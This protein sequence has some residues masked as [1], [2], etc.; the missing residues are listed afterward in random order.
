MEQ[1]ASLCPGL[2][3]CDRVRTGVGAQPPRGNVISSLESIMG[4]AVSFLVKAQG[5]GKNH[6][7]FGMLS[8]QH[9]IWEEQHLPQNAGRSDSLKHI[10]CSELPKEPGP[11]VGHKSSV[12][13]FEALGTGPGAS[14]RASSTL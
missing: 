9:G 4:S 14:S 5:R 8:P 12:L 13:G 7:A 11:H 10:K 3:W 2:M 1:G 6:A